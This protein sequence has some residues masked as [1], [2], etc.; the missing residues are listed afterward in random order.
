[1]I[2]EW[3]PISGF[4]DYAISSFGRV[5][6]ITG[7]RGTRV[8]KIRSINFCTSNGYGIISMRKEGKFHS[9]CVHQLVA[10]HFIGERP[11]GMQ[12]RHLDGDKKNNALSNLVYGTPKENYAD[13]RKHGKNQ[14]GERARNAKITNAQASTIHSLLSDGKNPTEISRAMNVSRHIV[15]HIAHGVAWKSANNRKGI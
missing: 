12:V 7:K 6:R 10:K 3:I 1:M 15:Y 14:E 5:K 13:A 11:D 9:R 8:G 4:E 2:E